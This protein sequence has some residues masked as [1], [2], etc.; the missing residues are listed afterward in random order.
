MGNEQ[1]NKQPQKSNKVYRYPG[2]GWFG[3]VCAGIAY[4]LKVQV[5]IVRL[6]TFLAIFLLEL[7]LLIYILCW[8]FMPKKRTPK[9]YNKICG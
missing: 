4:R 1:K 9:D 8:I 7:P 2:V 6:I 5:W 3:G